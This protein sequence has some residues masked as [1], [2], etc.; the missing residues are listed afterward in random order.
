M[1]FTITTEEI[2]SL[3]DAQARELV[4][5]LCQAE[6]LKNSHDTSLVT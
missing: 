1:F 4:A 2:Q 5:R 6:V 3:N